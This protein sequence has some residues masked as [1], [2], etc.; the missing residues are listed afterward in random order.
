[1]DFFQKG[2]SLRSLRPWRLLSS[3]VTTIKLCFKLE[4][5]HVCKKVILS[6]ERS[7]PMQPPAGLA[8]KLGAEGIETVL[9]VDLTLKNHFIQRAPRIRLMRVT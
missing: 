8:S 5:S 6:V 2:G 1:M 4:A 7:E 9:R 3:F